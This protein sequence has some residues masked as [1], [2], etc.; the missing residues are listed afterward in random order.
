MD[1]ERQKLA[2]GKLFQ[3]ACMREMGKF[4]D[5]LNP[6]PDRNADRR[7]R[8]LAR[9]LEEIEDYEILDQDTLGQM[10][11][12]LSEFLGAEAQNKAAQQKAHAQISETIE[13][14]FEIFYSQN[15]RASDDWTTCRWALRAMTLGVSAA[16]EDRNLL[17]AGEFDAKE[18]RIYKDSS[19][20]RGRVDKIIEKAQMK[21]DDRKGKIARSTKK[22]REKLIQYEERYIMADH[23]IS[24]LLEIRN[25]ASRNGTTVEAM[26]RKLTEAFG[27]LATGGYRLSELESLLAWEDGRGGDRSRMSPEETALKQLVSH[28]IIPHLDYF[29]MHAMSNEPD[30]ETIDRSAYPLIMRHSQELLD[31]NRPP[32]RMQNDGAPGLS[33]VKPVMDF[34]F[35]KDWGHNT[36]LQRMAEAL[37][38]VDG[39][40]GEAEVLIDIYQQSV[41]RN[42]QKISG[43]QA[44]GSSAATQLASTHAANAQIEK[45]VRRMERELLLVQ[46]QYENTYSTGNES[47][48]Q[49]ILGS[50]GYGITVALEDIPGLGGISKLLTD[51]S[52]S[53]IRRKRAADT[54]LKHK[55]ETG[56][57]SGKMELIRNELASVVPLEAQIRAIAIAI[58]ET[59]E[60]SEFLALAQ[61]KTKQHTIS[62]AFVA[63]YVLTFGMRVSTLLDETCKEEG[64][65]RGVDDLLMQF[66]GRSRLGEA[67]QNL[68]IGC[69]DSNDLSI[70]LA[71]TAS[72]N[73][74]TANPHEKVLKAF[75]EDTLKPN[76][77]EFYSH[78]SKVDLIYQANLTGIGTG[79]HRARHM[80]RDEHD[81]R[82]KAL[83][84]DAFGV[85]SSIHSLTTRGAVDVKRL[86][87]FYLHRH[88]DRYLTDAKI[89]DGMSA[90]GKTKKAVSVVDEETIE[91]HV[92]SAKAAQGYRQQAPE[93]TDTFLR[94]CAY[95]YFYPQ[96][97]NHDG[98]GNIM[99]EN[100][101]AAASHVMINAVIQGFIEKMSLGPIENYREKVGD[102]L[103]N[104]IAQSFIDFFQE[105]GYRH[106]SDVTLGEKRADLKQAAS[107]SGSYGFTF[108]AYSTRI[109]KDALGQFPLFLEI[110]K[111]NLE[112]QLECAPERVAATLTEQ[113]RTVDNLT[114]GMLTPAVRKPGSEEARRWARDEN[115]TFE[116]V[117]WDGGRR[118]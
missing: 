27:A 16:F 105:L 108:D 55:M 6:M 74:N 11:G 107:E 97:P 35:L 65:Q 19:A 61:D 68:V 110:Y 114:D 64:M 57:L 28:T 26:E 43:F 115:H 81:G 34:S 79:L 89:H 100:P 21:I 103:D 117:T 87:D 18:S 41:L 17:D 30:L 82:I 54:R 2:L 69:A 76:I 48:L 85:N 53:V 10:L 92:D 101:E 8:R 70:I 93:I 23:S 96:A 15:R 47:T 56:L 51:Q 59:R 40:I 106:A 77:A 84:G 95:D 78:A 116:N 109:T 66:G 75:V 113:I 86:F 31:I 7:I 73:T 67:V 58:E 44:Q 45:T 98:Q 62:E 9:L 104:L 33:N 1:Q 63:K 118:R 38:M 24:T 112:K 102:R 20:A 83:F 71:E 94:I 72:M 5:A 37:A 14:R 32:R 25:Y 36:H 3:R 12:E 29:V 4:K 88:G 50:M 60:N 22:I 99:K 46:A 49:A 80:V 91:R 13:N 42:L 39:K 90:G 52:E 111:R